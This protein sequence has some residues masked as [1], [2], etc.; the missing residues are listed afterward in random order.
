MENSGHGQRAALYFLFSIF[1]FLVLGVT[2]APGSEQDQEVVA[3]LSAGRVVIYVAKDG[4]V[5]GS[6]ENRFEAETRPPVVVPLSRR[7]IGVFLGA[8][9]WVLPGSGRKLVRL[10]REL[11]KLVGEIAGSRRLEPEQASDIENIGVAVLEPLRAAAQQLHRKI[12]LPPEEPLVELLLAG[13]AE[14]YGPEVWLLR[15]RIVQ[16]P[17]R[18][19]Y[20]RTRVLRPSY[21]QLYPPEKGQPRTLIEVHYPPGDGGAA[22]LDLLN[23]NDPRLER[24]RTANPRMTRAT[25]RLARGE[26]HKALLDDASEFLRAALGALAL[27][28][29]RPILAVIQEQRGFE[30]LLPPSELPEK[31]GE[32]QPHEP[33]APTLR[34]KP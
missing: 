6:L 14:E 9:E 31:A 30:W 19:D 22:L 15:Y 7:R 1:S 33:S 17:L 32:A 27:P 20:W 29:A 12:E 25:E 24:I 28:E 11:P 5:I 26:S 2:R 13:Y 23:R 18:G 10:D 3:N 8:V 34:K 21:T 4:I 16:E